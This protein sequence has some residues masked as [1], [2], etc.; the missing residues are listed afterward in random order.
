MGVSRL[1]RSSTGQAYGGVV[2]RQSQGLQEH[3]QS[4]DAE[5][6]LAIG[7]PEASSAP[8]LQ[9]PRLLRVDKDMGRYMP[10]LYLVSVVSGSRQTQLNLY[11]LVHRP[12]LGGPRYTV[13]YR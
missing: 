7:Q 4:S 2:D 10:L 9:Q 8:S 6:R 11:V 12:P 3:H 13:V 5:D 1:G